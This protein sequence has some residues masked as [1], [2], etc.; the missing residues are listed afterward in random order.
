MIQ[1]LL[2]LTDGAGRTVL[3]RA[4]ALFATG[5][6]L[7]G[8]VFVMLVPFLEA[9]FGGNDTL[10]MRWLCG[11]LA[12]GIAYVIVF[13]T[14][15]AAGMKAA[16]AVLESLLNKMGDR[17]VQ[18]PTG[19]FAKD[20]S[21]ELADTSSRG[22]VFAA[23][24]PYSILRPMINGLVAPATMIVGA[25][26]IDWR[27]AL[28][29][30]GSVP[31][32]IVVQR[33]LQAKIAQGDLEHVEAIQESSARLIEFA[34]V[35]PALRAAG[36]NSISRRIVDD[37]LENQHAVNHRFQ[38][39]GGAGIAVF[40]AVV[41]AVIVIVLAAGT[42][43]V[44]GG[45]LSVPAFVGI[46]VL[47]VRFTEPISSSGGLSGGV[48]LANNTLEVI[49]GLLD[50][51]T[52]SEPA[53]EEAKVPECFDVEFD[54]VTFGYE[55]DHR[56][57]NDIT[58]TAEDRSMT[59]I[60]GPSGC[61]K[62]TLTRLIARFYDPDAGTV[63]IGG[64]PLPEMGTAE[65]VRLVSPVF[66]DVYLFDGTI[67]DTIWMG[68]PDASRED[69]EEAARRA[70]VDEIVARL[71]HGW[72]TRVGEGGTN[73]SGGERQRISIARAL[74]KDSPVVVLDEATSALDVENEQA[75]Q[76]AL[77]EL[78]SGRTLIVVAH[79]L[80]TIAGADEII[81]LSADG[82]IAERGTHDELLA[83]DGGYARYW[84]ERTRASGWRLVG[85]EG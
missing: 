26:L 53:P 56:V 36:E 24:A 29:M 77:D 44:L 46:C 66:Q 41:R 38:M 79:R 16:M 32:I 40:G 2:S 37:A 15:S 33:W 54:H 19:W 49:Q 14:G 82:Q 71:P 81:M 45:S 57:L 83:A 17:L 27:L 42:W 70:R 60:V 59:A 43:M 1:R 84:G 30:A 85:A 11:M 72:D 5:A 76:A 35:Q 69:V 63:S 13:W 67:L 21:G 62:T 9:L 31:V 58:F 23:A 8:I 6:V 34:R 50:E 18:L 80:S 20:R 65:V 3:R 64:V 47:I 7:Q 75:I 48:A 55:P 74:L 28:V 73:L 78:R 51:D 52:L 10:M 12:V 4:I 68:K 25:F 61:G 39:T 22:I